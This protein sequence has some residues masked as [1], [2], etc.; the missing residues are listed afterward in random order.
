MATLANPTTVPTP[1]APSS[2]EHTGKLAA[3][4]HASTAAKKKTLKKWTIDEENFV[5]A[6]VAK[7][8]AS[9]AGEVDWGSVVEAFRE[10]FEIEDDV[11]LSK[12]GFSGRYKRV[13]NRRGEETATLEASR[14]AAALLHLA[15]VAKTEM[16]TE[17]TVMPAPHQPQPPLP[18]PAVM[19]MVQMPGLM[20]MAQNVELEYRWID[21]INGMTMSAQAGPLPARQLCERGPPAIYNIAAGF[22]PGPTVTLQPFKVEPTGTNNHA[23]IL[24]VCVP[25]TPMTTI[26]KGPHPTRMLL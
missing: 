16:K 26:Q 14:T 13:S 10:Q 18:N 12:T 23:R 22:E 1:T 4:V 8:S 21:P 5:I 11:H 25:T 17:A 9:S 20:Q 3:G 7:L 2:P 19:Q 15:P 24:C 6:E